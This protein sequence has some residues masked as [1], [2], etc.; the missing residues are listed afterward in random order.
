MLKEHSSFLKIEKIVHDE[1]EHILY[2]KNLINKNICNEV[3]LNTELGIT[4]LDLARLVSLLEDKF[5]IDP[6]ME[7]VSITSI[8]TVGDLVNTYYKAINTI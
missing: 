3:K 5:N 7:M 8:R 2:E 6:F 1:I 4:S